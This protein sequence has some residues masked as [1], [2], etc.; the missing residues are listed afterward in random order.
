M[1]MYETEMTE[2]PQ[3]PYPIDPTNPG[4]RENIF[5]LPSGQEAVRGYIPTA[6]NYELTTNIRRT[7]TAPVQNPNPGPGPGAGAAVQ[8]PIAL[9]ARK[10]VRMNMP[11]SVLQP[12]QVQH[13]HFSGLPIYFGV[14]FFQPGVS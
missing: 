12:L 4:E 13:F 10:E 2:Q 1:L 11:P 5:V 9:N 14:V 6:P 8:Q 7:N 3:T